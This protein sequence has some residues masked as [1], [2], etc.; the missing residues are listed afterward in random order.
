M[1]FHCQGQSSRWGEY[2]VCPVYKCANINRPA[3]ARN[4]GVCYFQCQGHTTVAPQPTYSASLAVLSA[5]LSSVGLPLLPPT[6]SAPSTASAAALHSMTRGWH[7]AVHAAS[8]QALHKR[9]RNW[10]EGIHVNP[11]FPVCL[12]PSFDGYQFQ[13]VTLHITCRQP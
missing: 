11:P 4:N 7:T 9:L 1:H 2:A 8:W 13:P 12:R 3:A 10:S 6:R 5:H